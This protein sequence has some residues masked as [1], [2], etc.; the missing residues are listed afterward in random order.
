MQ[1]TSIRT[2]LAVVLAGALCATATTAIAA[3]HGHG[4]IADSYTVQ[5]LN[6]AADQVASTALG[7]N[8]DGA[9]VGIVRP[10]ATAQP[11]LTAVWEPHGDHF[12][13]HQ[14]A[15]LEGSTFSRGFDIAADGTI[16]G[17]AF[18]TS[19]YTI[20]IKWN[21]QGDPIH[22]TNLNATSNGILNDISE[23]GVA[24]GTATIGSVG[25]AVTLSAAG[26]AAALTAPTPLVA[27]SVVKRYA[28]ATTAGAVI[29][30]T[31]TVDE[32]HGDHSHEYSYPVVWNAG[33]P[34]VLPRF[35]GAS[36]TTVAGVNTD[37][38]LVGSST[39]SGVETAL[40]WD[41][42]V[43]APLA[44]P[45]IEGHGHTA[46]K[47]INHSGI[48]V[49]YASKFA[50]N[51]SFGAAA[52]VWDDH[53]AR[54][55]NDLAVDL[56]EDVQ[57]ISANDINDAGQIVG[58]AKDAEGLTRGFIATPV[59]EEPVSTTLS[60][61]GLASSYAPGDTVTLTAVQDPATELDHYHWFTRENADA[62]WTVVPQLIAGTWTFTAALAQDG[63]QIQA[64]LY[65]DN[66][67][68]IAESAP[69]T[70]SVKAPVVVP[71][72]PTA[73]I[74]VTATGARYGAQASLKITATANNL[75]LTGQVRVTG[76]G[77]S[78]L[79]AALTGGTAS[80]KLPKT[81]AVGTRTFTVSYLGSAAAKASSTT[82]KVTI[83]KA[84]A[85]VSLKL[86]PTKIKARSTRAR[87]TIR[88]TVPGTS[89]SPNGKVQVRV[90]G[91]VVRTAKVVRGKA[92]V[93]LPKIA[94]R[95]TAKIRAT[96]VGTKNVTQ[97]SKTVKV[98]VRR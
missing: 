37:G 19:G 60:I 75:P 42:G 9:V 20:P 59:A 44:S 80:V 88:V 36:Y 43:A 65:D 66:H 52:I 67:N 83:A 74:A 63:Q 6:P 22:V 5:L 58:A 45:A 57:L 13:R 18:N 25:T 4:H 30:G 34:T 28:A 94:K 29:G 8:N 26:E 53:S 50:G 51:T 39:V 70:I 89:V 82:A 61:A 55:L 17:E 79:T 78:A 96:F 76:T 7:I 81:L 38:V 77:I 98:T 71:E 90:R 12:H 91:K 40:I 85:K 1:R 11:Q 93:R 56:A 48:A 33:V 86:K 24:V 27:D 3:G 16:A 64:R 68:V 73:K 49:G 41:D 10:A 14:L 84:R 47:A 35:E 72:I 15:N 92:T 54:N 62:A 23:A 46:A 95:G 31:V 32:P 87:A 69:V 97:A 21:A 2:S